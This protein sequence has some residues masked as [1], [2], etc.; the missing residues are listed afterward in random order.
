[1]KDHAKNIILTSL[2]VILILFGLLSFVYSILIGNISQLFWICYT[3]SLLIG[4]GLLMR[5]STLIAS[6][7]NI[8][9]ILDIVWL[10]DFV[11]YIVNGS[12]LF[13]LTDY[14]FI[15]HS[16]AA[17]II[18]LQHLIIIPVAFYA[19]S[20][21]PLKIKFSWVISLLQIILFGT[22]SY[23]LTPVDLNLN[24][25]FNPCLNLPLNIFYQLKWLIYMFINIIVTYGIVNL[26]F[27]KRLKKHKE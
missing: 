2:G 5:S 23:F 16:L 15:S 17:K 13:G 9:L 6:Q 25:I 11:S 24:C 14:F 19:L 8:L 20:K 4:I 3:G 7:L 10:I 27:Y 22:L 21:L 1:M 12:S 18:S 26:V